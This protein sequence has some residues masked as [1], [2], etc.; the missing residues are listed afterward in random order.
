MRSKN[1]RI[2]ALAAAA[3][4]LGFLGNAAR[5][6]VLSLDP[7]TD[8]IK[9][10]YLQTEP[11]ATPDTPPKPEKPLTDL[12]NKAGIKTGPFSVYGFVEGSYTYSF[13][14][15]PGNFITGRVF[16]IDNQELMLNQADLAIE[17][18]VDSA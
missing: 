5:A 10:L 13:S 4:C 1:R 18:T 2:V 3:C 17:K 12:M 8:D 16:D 6:D 15:P 7:Q 11:S 9:P 14:N